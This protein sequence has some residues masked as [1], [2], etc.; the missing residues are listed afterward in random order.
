MSECL[1]LPPASDEL[2]ITATS[3]ALQP[4]TQRTD[5]RYLI[6]VDR[7]A[8]AFDPRRTKRLETEVAFTQFAG[9]IRDRNR[10]GRRKRLHSRRD[11]GRVPNRRVFSPT[12]CGLE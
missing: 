11:T 4:R 5:A 12:F 10:S 9:P 2:R 1:H 6:Y 7:L 3:P 8:D